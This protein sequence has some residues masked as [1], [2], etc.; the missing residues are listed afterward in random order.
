MNA[1]IRTLVWAF[2]LLF[3]ALPPAAAPAADGPD[4]RAASAEWDRTLRKVEAELERPELTAATAGV[5][6][7][8]VDAVRGQAQG[9]ARDAQREAN[10]VNAL[11]DALG[12]APTEGEPDEA[13]EVRKKRTQLNG[14]LTELQSRIQQC[15]LTITRSD[16]L[17]KQISSAQIERQTTDLITRWPSLLKGDTWTK[18][19]VQALAISQQIL[20]R[21]VVKGGRANLFVLLPV[22]VGTW[23]AVVLGRLVRNRIRER[24]GRDPAI[25]DPSYGRRLIAAAIDGVA[26]GIIPVVVIAILLTTAWW[27]FVGD[28]I[29]PAVGAPWGLLYAIVF[30]LLAAALVRAIFSPELP[31]WRVV[32]IAAAAAARIGRRLNLIAL[33]FALD[34]GVSWLF[35]R[36]GE[37][38]E[39]AV[40]HSF[41]VNALLAAMVFSLLGKQLW[42]IEQ[43]PG[44]AY[45]ERTSAAAAA[46]SPYLRIAAGV[47][48]AFAVICGLAGYPTLADYLLHNSI[49]TLL[50][51]GAMLAL[52]FL[53]REAVVSLGTEAEGPAG[54]IRRTLG[55]S[56]H[57]GR[58][59]GFWIL[60]ILDM[61]LIVAGIAAGLLL[62]G[63]P[64]RALTD[65]LLGL[66][67]GF[68]VGSHRFSLADLLLAVAA[69][70]VILVI[71]RLV[72]RF[73]EFRLLPNTRMDLGVLSAITSGIGYVGVGIA[74][75]ASISTLGIDLTGL[76]VVAG[77]LSVGIGFG[78]QN[79]VNNFI[80]GI[81]L[82]IERPVKVGDTVTLRE[83]EGVVRRIRVRSTEIETG[84]HASVIIPN[85]DL[86]Q[87]ALINWTH[88]DRMA[89]GEVRITVGYGSD[90]ATVESVLRSCAA[91]HAT[92]LKR[93]A[94]AVLLT[95]FNE[96]GAEFTLGFQL[97][98][99]DD[100]G[101]V[102]SDLRKR[103]LTRLQAAGIEIPAAKAGVVIPPPAAA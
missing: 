38:Q 44:E 73:L 32:P 41:A 72:Q 66:F 33:V 35:D 52:R 62:W 23:L 92:V 67:Q 39:L 65:W 17:L 1:P 46:L 19:S 47:L 58:L 59:L 74:L 93:P 82:L 50:G 86:L 70:V 61:A 79:I 99:V 90:V 5:L 8:R 60:A 30:Y 14:T 18:A 10:E 77:A 56:E 87:A 48:A 95:A 97:A 45:G 54:A 85:A 20:A 68:N 51:V 4:F 96:R 78:L 102:A 63:I 28:R 13:T 103:I 57:G 15:D 69:F 6:R 53:L 37:P 98:D 76:A 71:T 22:A 91:E 3:L 89:R 83:H 7:Q 2:F 11:L 80:S 36:A 49:L 31:N 16:A 101:L 40:L 26:R 29:D 12:P 88:R 43:W 25:A 84:A 34:L 75:L 81:I 27:L 21:E 94:P 64:P 9:A 24:W 100:K 55:L 42:Q